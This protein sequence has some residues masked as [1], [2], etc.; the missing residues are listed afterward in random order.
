MHCWSSGLLSV[1]SELQGHS[2]ELT[3]SDQGLPADKM[4]K[5]G[6]CCFGCWHQ[7]SAD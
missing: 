6:L 2:S 1:S 7:K 4:G 5:L 3:R